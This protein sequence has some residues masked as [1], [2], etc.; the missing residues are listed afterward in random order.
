MPSCG[1]EALQRQDGA[2]SSRLPSLHDEVRTFRRHGAPDTSFGTNLADVA[3]EAGPL[4]TGGAG[5]LASSVWLT[6]DRHP[7]LHDRSMVGGRLRRTRLSSLTLDRVPEP[8]VP[9]S[10]VV[11]RLGLAGGPSYVLLTLADDTMFDPVQA[12]LDAAPSGAE[13]EIWLAHHDPAALQRWRPRTGAR[14]VN[15]LETARTSRGLEKRV[16]QLHELG[17]DAVS[18]HH[19]EWSGGAV[20]MAHRFGLLAV[21]T[22]AEHE[23]EL[24]AL[25]HAGIDGLVSAHVDRMLAVVALYYPS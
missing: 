19:K 1:I 16:A 5:G 8:V 24:A 13:S 6:S 23:R 3:T 11:D 18:A 21:A 9:L 17:V 2:V 12:V 10:T 20:A 25:V 15:V 4:D 22:G 14:L 7:V